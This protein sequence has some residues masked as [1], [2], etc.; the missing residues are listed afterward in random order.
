M[1]Q[2]KIYHLQDNG[3]W[4]SG[5][6]TGTDP[7][8]KNLFSGYFVENCESECKKRATKFIIGS[9]IAAFTVGVVLTLMIK[10]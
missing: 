5:V 4:T 8:I 9:S 1:N 7:T 6:G 2:S 10:K 3:N